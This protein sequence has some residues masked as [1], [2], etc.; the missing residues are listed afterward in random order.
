MVPSCLSISFTLGGSLHNSNYTVRLDDLLKEA[1]RSWVPSCLNTSVTLVDL[2]CNLQ[3]Y[4]YIWCIMLKEAWRSWVPY[5][6]CIGPQLNSLSYSNLHLK[7]KSGHRVPSCSNMFPSPAQAK[8][9]SQQQGRNRHIFLRGQSLFSWFFSPAW[10]A[11]TRYRK[12]P[13]W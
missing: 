9:Y 1:W 5:F 10:N 11:F 7:D 8:T 12:F 6:C 2:L 3:W 13:F 4:S